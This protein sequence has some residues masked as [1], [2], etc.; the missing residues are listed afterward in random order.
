MGTMADFCTQILEVDSLKRWLSA[1]DKV[2]HAVFFTDRKTTPPLVKALSVEYKG[3]AAIGVV[4]AGADAA[5]AERLEVSK[6]PAMLHVTDEDQLL[7]DHFD[8]DFK[9]E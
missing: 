8:K 4:V 3:R 1:D 5:L 7:A 2:P 6:R 9:K